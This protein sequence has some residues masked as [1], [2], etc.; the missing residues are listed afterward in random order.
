MEGFG[1]ILGGTRVSWRVVWKLSQWLPWVSL[2]LSR[3]QARE[4]HP[5]EAE[6]K[7]SP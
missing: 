1:A 6:R 4:S 7:S 3:V 5:E 2:L